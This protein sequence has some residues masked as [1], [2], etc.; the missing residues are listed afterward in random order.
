MK[1]CQVC[2]LLD[3]PAHLCGRYTPQMTV[4]GWLVHVEREGSRAWKWDSS[5]DSRLWFRGEQSLLSKLLR[6]LLRRAQ[7]FTLAISKIKNL[8][9]KRYNYLSE[10]YTFSITS[11]YRLLCG[12]VFHFTCRCCFTVL[13]LAQWQAHLILDVFSFRGKRSPSRWWSCWAASMTWWQQ[14][15]PLGG[16]QFFSLCPRCQGEINR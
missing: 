16:L 14:A 8:E 7:W 5:P 2:C 3:P 12:E 13:H 6:I 4:G 15:Q 1:H 10:L 9:R 11:M